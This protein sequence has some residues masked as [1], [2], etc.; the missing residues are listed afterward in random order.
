MKRGFPRPQMH[1]EQT[2]TH[3]VWNEYGK[4]YAYVGSYGERWDNKNYPVP[5]TAEEDAISQLHSGRMRECVTFKR[6]VACGESIQEEIVSLML[7]KGELHSESGP[8]HDKCARLTQNL[9]P[10]INLGSEYAFVKRRWD[11]VR[12][13]LANLVD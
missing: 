9:C 1:V 5:Y 3:R 13:I 10:H 12:E 11:E 8:F 6:C 7:R 2:Q 4:S